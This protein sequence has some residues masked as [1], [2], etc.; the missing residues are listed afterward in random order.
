MCMCVCYV[1]VCQ[2]YVRVCDTRVHV[3]L[4]VFWNSQISMDH[5]RRSHW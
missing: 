3:I 5:R 2:T 4:C 1:H